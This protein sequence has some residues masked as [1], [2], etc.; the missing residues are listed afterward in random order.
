MNEEKVFFLHGFIR[1]FTQQIQ[2]VVLKTGH[3]HAVEIGVHEEYITKQ[4]APACISVG[5]ED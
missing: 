1:L 4:F 5:K 2:P 3:R